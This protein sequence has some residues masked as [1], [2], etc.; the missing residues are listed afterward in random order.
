M[1]AL[2]AAETM[3]GAGGTVYASRTT[4]RSRAAKVQPT[5]QA[6]VARHAPLRTCQV[7]TKKGMQ[8]RLFG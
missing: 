6:A 2:V 4:S 3:T 8:R 5:A 7:L 1:I